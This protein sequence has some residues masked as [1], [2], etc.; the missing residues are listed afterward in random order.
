[1]LVA[2]KEVSEEGKNWRDIYFTAIFDGSHF[3]ISRSDYV[4][5][6]FAPPVDTVGEQFQLR[7]FIPGARAAIALKKPIVHT[8][9]AGIIKQDNPTFIDGTA[10]D[11]QGLAYAVLAGLVPEEHFEKVIEHFKKA[12]S[13]IGIQVFVPISGKTREEDEWLK[14]VKG[15]VVWPHVSWTAAKALI[16]MGALHMAEEQIK[17]LME[18][19]DCREWVACDPVTGEVF[20]G[21]DPEQG[22]SATAMLSGMAALKEYYAA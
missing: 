11:P 22:W 9:V 2:P 16:K 10:I 8:P 18:H 5:T 21:G 4:E 15:M 6:N 3:V 19:C 14:N 1:M 13:K 20:K 12:D 17:K 7:D